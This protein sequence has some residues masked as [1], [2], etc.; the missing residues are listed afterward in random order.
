MT[1]GLSIMT[2]EAERPYTHRV[3]MTLSS[4]ERD[5]GVN[6]HIKWDP[7]IDG[8]G[9]EEIGYLPASYQFLQQ[10][11]LPVLEDAYLE[12]NFGYLLDTPAEGQGNN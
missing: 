6:V 3:T 5:D 12:S 2:E 8:K 11:I 4:N 9:I 10:Y 1:S 7:D